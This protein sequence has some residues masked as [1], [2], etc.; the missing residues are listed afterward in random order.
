MHPKIVGK[1]HLYFVKVSATTGF[2]VKGGGGGQ[3]F[4]EMSA[5]NSL[6]LFLIDAFPLKLISKNY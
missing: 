3:N 1:K 5:T 2:S 4:A 6:F